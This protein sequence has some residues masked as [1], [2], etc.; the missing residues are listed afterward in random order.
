MI[1]GIKKHSI[2]ISGHQTSVSL[3]EP[4][5]EELKKISKEYNLS[6]AQ[7]IEKIDEQP[8]ETSLASAIRLYILAKLTKELPYLET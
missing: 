8:R 6:L 7:L 1:T 2:K 3:E 4:F 5:W